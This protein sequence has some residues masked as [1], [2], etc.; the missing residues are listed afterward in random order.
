MKKLILTTAAV[1][2]SLNLFAQGTVTFSNFPGNLVNNDDASRAV[3]IADG[4]VAALYYAPVGETAF[5]LLA[6]SETTIGIPVD[7]VIYGTAALATGTDVAPGGQ[8]QF[9]VQAWESSFGDYDTAYAGGGL[10]G[11]S[12]IWTQG[13]GG[14]GTP[15]GPPVQTAI[16]AFGV[17]VI[18]E[19][20]AIALG[21]L[22]AGALLLLR[23]RK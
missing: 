9:F 10:V 4:V 20:S 19:P 13:T 21:L 16:P 11:E 22:G 6:G 5:T 12:P 3:S 7:G 18:P 2:T 1:L 23:R 17:A 15:P 8:A 14:G